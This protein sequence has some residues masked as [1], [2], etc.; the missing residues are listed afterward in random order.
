MLDGGRTVKIGGFG[1]A[2][3]FDYTNAIELSPRLESAIPGFCAPEVVR[4]EIPSTSAD[5]WSIM[6]VLV[7]MLTGRMPGCSKY[8][9][10]ERNQVIMLVSYI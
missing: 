5:I 7:L 6:C 4:Q 2:V 8:H 9:I 10:T 1:R 3:L